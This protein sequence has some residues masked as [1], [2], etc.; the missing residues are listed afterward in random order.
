[1][2]FAKIGVCPLVLRKLVPCAP[3]LHGSCGSS[4]RKSKILLEGAITGNASSGP[5]S[6]GFWMKLGRSGTS[7]TWDQKT[8][9]VSTCSMNPGGLSLIKPLN[10]PF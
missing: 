3:F 2:W 1:M 9:T 8:G 4:G 7:S 5:Q 6:E 10:G